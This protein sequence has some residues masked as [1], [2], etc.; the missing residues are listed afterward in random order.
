MPAQWRVW[1]AMEDQP[2][3][4]SRMRSGAVAALAC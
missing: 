4:G 2:M 3:A 1:I